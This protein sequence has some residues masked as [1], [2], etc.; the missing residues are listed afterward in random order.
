M[1]VDR[2]AER[3]SVRAQIRFDNVERSRL[4]TARHRID[5]NGGV[6][7]VLQR[8]G[9]VEAANAEVAHGDISDRGT[10]TE[11]SRDA[12]AEAIVA[13]EDVADARDQHAGSRPRCVVERLDLLWTK[14]EPM[15]W[16]TL[17]SEVATWTVVD[18]H[19]EMRLVVGRHVDRFD[20]GQATGERCVH[21]VAV[22][23]RRESHA[24][25]NRHRRAENDDA[26]RRWRADLLPRARGWIHA[27]SS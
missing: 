20:R 5:E 6:V 17:R 26:R 23:A 11:T 22:L 8:V 25:P 21:H 1:C 14:E 15:A 13:E 2:D 24:L 3:D 19:A 4:A 9:E 27:P 18:G 10:L 16:V 7:S 12:H